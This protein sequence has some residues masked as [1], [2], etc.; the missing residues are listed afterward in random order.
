MRSLRELDTPQA[1]YSSPVLPEV[2]EDRAGSDDGTRFIHE[3][4]SGFAG[5]R[6]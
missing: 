6:G 1:E 2:R 3:R 5:T 4:P